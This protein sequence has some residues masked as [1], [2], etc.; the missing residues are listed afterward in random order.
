MSVTLT[1]DQLTFLNAFMTYL[2][3]AFTNGVTHS[4]STVIDKC[5]NYDLAKKVPI[6][7][8]G[9]QATDESEKVKR[10][11]NLTM[12]SWLKNQEPVWQTSGLQ[13]PWVNVGFGTNPFGYYKDASG[14]VY[15]KGDVNGGTNANQT[16]AV[17]PLGYWPAGICY[18]PVFAQ[19]GA[20]PISCFVVVSSVDGTITIPST[21]VG[22][23]SDLS[24]EG[25]SFQTI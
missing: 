5:I 22:T 25:I 14:R 16:V 20:G 4:S 18:F 24:L 15:L 3:E 17:L 21:P 23:Y 19:Q 7:T 8:L 2:E 6:G 12:A 9:I 10:L 11:H 13:S 1:D